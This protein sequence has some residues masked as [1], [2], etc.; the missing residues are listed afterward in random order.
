MKYVFVETNWVVAS[1]APVHE[2]MPASLELVERAKQGEIRLHLPS[3]C[4]SEARHPIRSKYQPRA[5]ADAIRKF[6]AWTALQE[7]S[8]IPDTDVIRRTLDR[9]ETSVLAELDK[10]PAKLESIRK[11]TGL[12]V[13][14]LDEQMLSRSVELSSEDLNLKPYDHA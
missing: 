12:E 5:A 7:D 10:L 1:S 6:L 14:P 3:I 4:L 2:R 13:F 8:E 9:F 11:T